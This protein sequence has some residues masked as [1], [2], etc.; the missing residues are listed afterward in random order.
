MRDKNPITLGTAVLVASSLIVT[1][2]GKP[3][4]TVARAAPGT[5]TANDNRTPA[6]TYV[7]D[8]LVLRLTLATVAWHLLGDSDPALTVAAFAEEGK[9]PTIPAPLLRVRTGTPI[10]VMIQNP[11]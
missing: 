11:F 9:T 6:G 10:H 7:G 3:V 5:V 1:V 2:A 4:A 8:T